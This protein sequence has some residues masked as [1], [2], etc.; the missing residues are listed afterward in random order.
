MSGISAISSASAILP[1][2][3]STDSNPSSLT[4]DRAAAKAADAASVK[5]DSQLTSDEAAK[6]KAATI[7]ADEQTAKTA[8]AA[9]QQ[10]DAKAQSD[11]ASSKGGINVTA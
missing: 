6:A 8:E 10:A 7:K 9:A 3:A 5:A 1:S 11:A 4:K 2:T